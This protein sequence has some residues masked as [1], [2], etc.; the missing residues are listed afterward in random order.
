[1]LAHLSQF[2][3]LTSR[4][5]GFLPRRSTL[6][7][8]LVAE[9]LITKWLDEGSAVDLIYLDFS[10][11][12]DSVN[13]RL[14]LDKPRGYGAA[15]IILSWVKCSLSRRTS[16]VKVN[17]TLSQMAEAIS[18]VPQGS[19]IGPILLAIYVNDLPGHLSADSRLYADDVKLIAPLNR[20]DILQ[21]S[22]NISTSWSRDWE[23]DLNTTKSEHL[24]I[25][26]SPNS[27]TYTLPPHN[28]PNTQTIPTATTTKDLGIVLNIR[29]SAVKKP[30]GCCFT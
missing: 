27:L 24:P 13:H 11:A 16:Q 10:K 22:L 23:L 6:T 15:P 5:H 30:V 3:L 17:G 29:L 4:Q 9:E 12:F 18:D 25:G 8:L 28:P 26:S 7:N 19:V 1:M 21:T 14:L 20:H 2:L